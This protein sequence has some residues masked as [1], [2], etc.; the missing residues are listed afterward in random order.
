MCDANAELGL[1]SEEVH[2]LQP[3][4]GTQSLYIVYVRGDPVKCLRHLDFYCGK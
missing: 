4:K 2:A 3:T 1:V